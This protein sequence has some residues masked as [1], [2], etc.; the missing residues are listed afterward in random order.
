MS[1]E[2][3]AGVTESFRNVCTL[4]LERASKYKFSLKMCLLSLSMTGGKRGWEQQ[5]NVPVVFVYKY[6]PQGSSRACNNLGGVTLPWSIIYAALLGPHKAQIS[7]LQFLQA[8]LSAHSNVTVNTESDCS[9]TDGTDFQSGTHTHT[10]FVCGEGCGWWLV[11]TQHES[12]QLF[13]TIC[14]L[15]NVLYPS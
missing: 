3:T 5:S 1:N 10:S 6:E 7:Q 9:E 14:A 12:N 11:W 8:V 4:T 13:I 2:F 15:G